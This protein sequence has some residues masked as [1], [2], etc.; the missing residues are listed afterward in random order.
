MPGASAIAIATLGLVALLFW[1]RDRSRTDLLLYTLLSTGLATHLLL[2]L[3]TRPTGPGRLAAVLGLLLPALGWLLLLRFLDLPLHR[4]RLALLALPA[5][6]APL[7]LAVPAA[8]PF[9][10]PAGAVAL[11][12]FGGAALVDLARLHRP[13]AALLFAA[14]AALLLAALFD[15]AVASGVLLP[16]ARL[17]P[18]LGPSFLAFT[19]LLLVAVADR[20]RLLLEKAT[21]DALTGLPNRAT[22]LE[23]ARREL[24]RAERNGSSLALAMLDIDHFKRFNDTYG[25]AAGNVVLAGVAAE[26]GKLVRKMDLACRYGGEEFIVILTKCDQDGVQTFAERVRNAVESALFNTEAGPLSV[27]VS[28]GCASYRAG[29]SYETFFKRADQALYRAKQNGRNRVEAA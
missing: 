21:T 18:L 29:D 26:I 7:L 12:L 9:G 27:T 3:P 1:A 24:A 14:T 17:P 8:G 25:H 4:G 13:D 11:V 22:F 20:G 19:A 5:V 10:A 28:V 15:A 6:C 16:G 23:R 2:D